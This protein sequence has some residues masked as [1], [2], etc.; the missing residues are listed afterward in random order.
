M[1]NIRVTID[2]IE[3][4]K[5]GDPSG[6]GQLYWL[7]K[8]NNTTI[9]SKSVSAPK[10]VSSGENIDINATQTITVD[11]NDTLRVYL[12]VSDKDSGFDGAD[13]SVSRNLTYDA[14]NNW[15]D[16]PLRVNLSDG[17]LDVTVY[18]QIDVV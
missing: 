12:S 18:G 14:S 17:P 2:Q 15:G 13:E 10:K 7:F 5:D 11:D 4:T 3:V 16:G 6:K 8:A 1:P 9:S